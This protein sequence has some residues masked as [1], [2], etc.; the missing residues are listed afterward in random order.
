MANDAKW[1]HGIRPWVLLGALWFSIWQAHAMLFTDFGNVFITCH[2]KKATMLMN[3]SEHENTY[4]F[5][6]YYTNLWWPF[7]L[8]A[9]LWCEER[10]TP[11]AT[12]PSWLSMTAHECLLDKLTTIS[13]VVT[14]QLGEKCSFCMKYSFS[15][16]YYS[17]L[18]SSSLLYL[19]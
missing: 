6:Y 19:F 17:L 11:S 3:L 16:C 9:F 8:F 1:T 4:H 13:Q 15:L 7:F 12:S 5:V 10:T 18:L 14:Y 2:A